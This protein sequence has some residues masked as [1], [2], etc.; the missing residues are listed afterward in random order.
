[1]QFKPVLFKVNCI[2]SL[3][4]IYTHCWLSVH[5]CIYKFTPS[6]IHTTHTQMDIVIHRL[7]LKLACVYT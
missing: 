3:M 1:M 2:S 4:H 5:I 6:Y 7:A